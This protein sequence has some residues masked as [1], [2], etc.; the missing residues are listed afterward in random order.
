MFLN[1]V[2]VVSDLLEQVSR[3]P[4][5]EIKRQALLFLQKMLFIMSYKPIGFCVYGFGQNVGIREIL[6]NLMGLFDLAR[7]SC[8]TCFRICRMQKLRKRRQ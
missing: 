8:G 5:R 7:S 3:R 4:D 2:K 1:S 6:N